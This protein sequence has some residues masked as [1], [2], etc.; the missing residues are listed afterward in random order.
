MNS[1]L[2]KT[3]QEKLGI[4]ID[5]IL[6]PN[7]NQNMSRW[8]VVAC[9]QYTS[10]PEYWKSVSEAIENSPSTY[11]LIYPEVFLDHESETQKQSR[12]KTIN[13]KM[14]TY[15]S[16]NIFT[17][18]T[19][20]MI[21]V[22]RTSPDGKKRI[23]LMVSL[24]LERYDFSKNSQSLIRATEGTIVERLPPR[25]K[26]RENACLE[27]PHIMV[28]IDDPSKT[29]IEPLYE[30]IVSTEP[31]YSFNLMM[32]SGYLNGWKISDDESIGQFA[33]NLLT[34][35][36][37]TLF[38]QKHQTDASKD[39][40]L[41]AVG[42]GNHS[43]ATAKSC[44][45]NLKKTLPETDLIDHPARYALVEIVNVHDEGLYFE[46]IHRILFN[47]DFEEFTE[48]MKTYFE[49]KGCFFERSSD[50]DKPINVMD[51]P[52]HILPFI[53][54]SGTGCFVI[55]KPLYTLEVATLQSFL[56]V[57]MINHPESIIDY[58]HGDDVTA[59]LG[60]KPGN[61]GFFLP[62]MNKNDLFHTVIV[63]GALPRKTFSMGEAHEKRFYTECRK[64]CR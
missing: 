8:S 54:E 61:I 11:H 60:S 1:E 29:V 6:L 10:E 39:V 55:G 58:V 32:D 53:T 33:Q 64:I 42:D 28:L 16:R 36:D 5:S 2:K 46:P 7:K 3:M 20:S 34:L 48:Q 59:R 31:V 35:A 22:E 56:D 13:H 15:L 18:Y 30:K 63:D 43:L 37:P 44:W 25:I 19:D 27:L 49:E 57:W 12:I 50:M 24:D 62:V 51:K 41:F 45:E 47:A 52:I 26:I 38:Q 14:E 9:D 17:E 23:G 40:V 21:L 4:N